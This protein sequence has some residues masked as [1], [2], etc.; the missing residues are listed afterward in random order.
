MEARQL[1]LVD[2]DLSSLDRLGSASDDWALA[3]MEKKRFDLVIADTFAKEMAGIRFL[4]DL[5]RLSPDT[6]VILITPEADLEATVGAVRFGADDYIVKP[7]SPEALCAAAARC[8]AKID[9]RKKARRAVRRAFRQK[10]VRFQR[11]AD[12]LE[13][14]YFETDAHGDPVFVNEYLSRM[15]GY[16]KEELVTM[17]VSEFM[18]P[19]YSDMF[20]SLLFDIGRTKH[21]AKLVGVEFIR[22]DGS[23][24]AVDLSA[25]P[26]HDDNADTGGICVVAREKTS[27]EQATDQMAYAL[28]HD[29]LTGLKNR[30][31][32]F[33]RL[34]EWLVYTRRYK[35]GIALLL[36]DLDNFHMVNRRYG[37]ATGNLVLKEAANRLRRELRSSDLIFR[38]GGDEFA[39]ILTNPER[40]IPDNA[41]RRI[42]EQLAL[43]YATDNDDIDFIR[44]NIGTS[45]SSE[46]YTD[47]VHMLYNADRSKHEA[48]ARAP[49]TPMPS[50]LKPPDGQSPRFHAS[51]ELRN[52]SSGKS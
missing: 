32:F 41:A 38:F 16:S 33:E 9:R 5:K 13:E 11:L 31:A 39:V 10:D 20:F 15:L 48:G 37:H 36:I 26:L 21:P 45:V 30:K 40:M 23:L 42:R 27:R 29:A 1:L 7:C 44:V 8:F 14:G 24:A 2:Q 35:T 17:K 4:K 49:G 34:D 28:Y 52:A 12:M 47:K 6:M 46:K 51:N 19:K 50:A 3:V 43:P 18:E 25:S 22:K